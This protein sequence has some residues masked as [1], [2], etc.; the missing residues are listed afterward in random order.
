MPWE[1]TLMLSVN[2]SFYL[3]LAGVELCLPPDSTLYCVCFTRT[4]LR[5]QRGKWQMPSMN[6]FSCVAF[7]LKSSLSTCHAVLR[8]NDSLNLWVFLQLCGKR[9]K[10]TVGFIQRDLW[11]IS[12]LFWHFIVASSHRW[13]S[14]FWILEGGGG[15][16]EKEP[17]LM[18]RKRQIF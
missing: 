16:N 12:G 9:S 15:W 17:T 3:L 11:F 1:R 2:R 6:L 4:S 8:T 5:H 14:F 10:W 13:T 18:K 7:Q